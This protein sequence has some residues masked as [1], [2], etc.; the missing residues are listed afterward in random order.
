MK[1]IVKSIY[2]R[3]MGRNMDV[4]GIEKGRLG[5][6]QNVFNHSTG[7]HMAGEKAAFRHR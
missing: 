3:I 4:F 2:T 1:H 6:A 7:L 5:P